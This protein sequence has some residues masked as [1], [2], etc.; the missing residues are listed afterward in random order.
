MGRKTAFGLTFLTNGCL[1]LESLLQIPFG[2]S[3]NGE[4]LFSYPGGE[5]NMLLQKLS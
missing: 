5:K 3:N 4:S 1:K 2:K